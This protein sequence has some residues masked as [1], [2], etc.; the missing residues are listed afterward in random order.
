KG[1]R[2]ATM[3]HEAV[4]SAQLAWQQQLDSEIKQSEFARQWVACLEVSADSLPARLAGYINLVAAPV[5]ALSVDPF[6]GGP[7]GQT[8]NFALL[9]PQEADQVTEAEFL[10]LAR[11]ARRW[12]LVGSCDVVAGCSV[13][14]AHGKQASTPRGRIPVTLVPVFF[15]RLWQYLHCDIWVQEKD[16]L[17]C[18]LRPVAPDQ[19]PWLESERV[20]DF[21][22]TELRILTLP[23]GRPMLA[24]VVFPPTM[25]I[26]QAKEYIYKEL[27]EVPVRPWNPSLCWREEP[28]RLVLCLPPRTTGCGTPV[29]VVLGS[30]VRELI[31]ATP[32]TEGTSRPVVCWQTYGVEFDR[33]AG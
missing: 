23:R 25:T 14:S 18:H 13:A 12:V 29:P 21:P 5:N 27:D 9:V 15:H 30:G 1:P 28:E 20:A 10:N 19:R 11:R 3:T 17:C 31:K 32:A 2:P 7:A 4:R 16:R 6:L 8:S 22:D 24:E 26:Q 33:S